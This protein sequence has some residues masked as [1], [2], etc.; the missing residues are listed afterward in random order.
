MI[1]HN[2]GR[3]CSVGEP[4]DSEFSTFCLTEPCAQSSLVSGGTFVS[5]A[6]EYD[7]RFI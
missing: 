2:V 5:F 7:F 6:S 1:R 4:R 3:T